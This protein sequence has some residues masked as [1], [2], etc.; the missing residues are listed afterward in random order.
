MTILNRTRIFAE[1]PQKL[2][3]RCSLTD[4]FVRDVHVSFLFFY[5]HALD[6][7]ALARGLAR[8][9]GD[10]A[11]FNAR[12]RQR[13]VE[14]FIECGDTGATFTI[15]RSDST[16][17][18]TVAQLDD[19]A[20]L[21]LVD[22]ID[23]R[24]TWSSG[25]PVL[26]VRVT[27][28]TDGQTALGV[29][30]HHTVGDLQS[31]LCLL[32]AWSREVAGLGYDKPVLVENRDEYLDRRLPATDHVE[33]N[34][35]YLRLRELPRLAAYMLTKAR[36]KRRI[37][38][39]FDPDE[40]ERMRATLQSECGQRVSINDALTAHVCSVVS[41][42]DPKARDRRVSISVNFRKRAGLP[43]NLLGNMVTTVDAAYE[44]GKPV[45][46]LAADLRCA[47]DA[48]AEKYL[49]HRANLRL[50]ESHG[51]F[52]KIARFIPIAIDP[53]SGS[54]LLSSCSGYGLYDVD[55]GVM[56]PSHFLTVGSGP[57]PWLGVVHEGFRNRGRIVDI[58]LPHDVTARMLDDVG[59]REVHRYRDPE[60]RADT[61]SIPAW[62]A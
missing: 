25:D 57:I 13:G 40:L 56:A 35:R 24:R 17:T 53:F 32:R 46:Q 27:H 3:I 31:V 42:R 41:A 21:A 36:D 29:S 33:A 60:A 20:R 7:A 44:W 22:G 52:A 10:F 38:L 6:T 59:R 15:A 47:I 34:L 14:R 45:A 55:F 30:W 11:P 43:E 62:V 8:V 28:F 1:A 51:G 26:A 19:R 39:Y 48:F 9:L 37:T 16:L 2:T 12:L 18:A 49:N 5:S 50:V 23:A 4:V 61:D 58:E 54:L